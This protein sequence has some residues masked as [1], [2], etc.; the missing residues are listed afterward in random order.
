MLLRTM[1]FG[2]ELRSVEIGGQRPRVPVKQKPRR[3]LASVFLRTFLIYVIRA[4]AGRTRSF[5]CMYA[6]AKQPGTQKQLQRMSL[7]TAYI[8]Q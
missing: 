4:V 1:N 2:F 7:G 6:R 3:F 8:Y 5:I